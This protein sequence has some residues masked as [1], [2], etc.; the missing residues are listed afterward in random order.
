MAYVIYLYSYNIINVL[1]SRLIFISFD[2]SCFFGCLCLGVREKK[3]VLLFT[4]VIQKTSIIIQNKLK[5][6]WW[7]GGFA[8]QLVL[9]HLK[10]TRFALARW[11][12]PTVCI[13]SQ[14]KHERSIPLIHQLQ[15]VEFAGRGSR[16]RVRHMVRVGVA[17]LDLLLLPHEQRLIWL[18]E[19]WCQLWFEWLTGLGVAGHCSDLGDGL[20]VLIDGGR[21]LEAIGHWIRDG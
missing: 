9:D 14:I 1:D 10:A 15:V 16:R 8:H 12:T 11:L 5:S 6:Y 20:G 18:V 2:S 7:W 4:W 13:P 21:F 17:L 19:A 3:E